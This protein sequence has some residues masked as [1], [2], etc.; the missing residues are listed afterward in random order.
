MHQMLCV[1]EIVNTHGVRGEI[2]VIPLVDDISAFDDLKSL[3][4]EVMYE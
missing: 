4:V 1:G 2:K 3:G